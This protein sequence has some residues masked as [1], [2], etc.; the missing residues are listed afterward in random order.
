MRTVKK[1]IK[2]YIRRNDKQLHAIVEE[3]IKNKQRLHISA[4][5]GTG[6]TEFIMEIVKRYKDKYQI[7]ILEPQV[8]IINQLKSD[9]KKKGIRTFQYEYNTRSKF[10]ENDLEHPIISTYDSGHRLI[11]RS[12]TDLNGINPKDFRLLDPEN[13]IVIMDESHALITDGKAHYDKS[14][15][16]IKN[17]GVPIIAFSATPSTWVIKDLLDI[18][19]AVEITS[20]SILP[21]EVVPVFI[22][23]NRAATLAKHIVDH[24]FKKVVIYT[25][26]IT[27]QNKLKEKILELDKNK[28]ILVLNRPEKMKKMVETSKFP[29][30]VNILMMNKVAQ[31]GI[32][33]KDTDI[34]AVF[35]V[36]QFDPIGFIQYMGRTRNYEGKYY[37]AYNNYG[38]QLDSEDQASA[39]DMMN[40]IIRKTIAASEFMID[41]ISQHDKLDKESLVK[42]FG[43]KYDLFKEAIVLNKCL[44][45]K[46]EYDAYTKLHG[47]ST[48]Q[49]VLDMN[50]G[51]E[52]NDNMEIEPVKSKSAM[53]R[54]NVIEQDIVDLISDTSISIIQ[55]TDYL[56]YN[57][58][59]WNDFEY[60]VDVSEPTSTKALISKVPLIDSKTKRRLKK[61]ITK[62]NEAGKG[63]PKVVAAAYAYHKDQDKDSIIT[64][65]GSRVSNRGIVTALKAK[66]Y[67][68]NNKNNVKAVSKVLD[69]IERYFGSMYQKPQWINAI[70]KSV[71]YIAGS[72]EF[73]D[74]IYS[75]FCDFSEH[76]IMVDGEQKKVKKLNKVIRSYSEYVKVKGEGIDYF[77]DS[78]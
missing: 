75:M 18:N 15:R 38:K 31:A 11:N 67:F 65:L 66:L 53:N 40:K 49:V 17:S 43:D 5:T 30:G 27:D 74:M 61:L 77:P 58:L 9:L 76:Q 23:K 4:P 57:K 41:N 36:G 44:A 62:A 35:L 45:A 19:T 14:I 33:I 54:K 16:E 46:T 48:F 68:L 52:Y 6:K 2:R 55:L 28:K 20:D 32:N 47:L 26:N 50:A 69:S 59:T 56:R 78:P 1:Q 7:L 12:F 37:F 39:E 21:K 10:G 60:L 13:T 73:A 70:K 51:I 25:P 24:K 72:D 8:A 22:Q 34:E 63:V 71:G 64:I 3:V 29:N 42:T